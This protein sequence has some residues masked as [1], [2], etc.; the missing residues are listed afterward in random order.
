MS[1]SHNDTRSQVAKKEHSGY[2]KLI[3][4]QKADDLAYQIYIA[5]R[6]FPR[7]EQFGLISQLRRSAISVPTNIVEGAGRQNKG[8]LK[9]FLN[10]ALGSLSEVEYLLN[11]CLRLGY[12]KQTEFER[13]EV[14]RKYAGALLWRFYKVL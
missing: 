5:T 7:D 12:L 2:K 4:W 9:Q 14:L 6:L 8:E 10:I 11:F 1:Q 3:V 13:L